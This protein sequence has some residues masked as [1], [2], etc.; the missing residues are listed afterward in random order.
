M[1]YPI[2]GK[3]SK[4]SKIWDIDGNEYIDISMG[5][6][7]NLFG[8]NADFIE[9][10]MQEQM[11]Y[12]IQ[13]GPQSD[14]AAEVALLLSKMTGVERV[15]FCNSGTEAIMTA[16][17]L[18]RTH[19]GRQKIALF[20]GAYH[21]HFDGV[22]GTAKVLNE[23]PEG[24]AVAPGVTHNT[25]KDLIVLDYDNPA[26]FDLLRL[27]QG[28]LAAV[29]V[30]P[31]QS[32]RPHL[33]PQE[34]L[35]QLRE[36]TA[37]AGIA[38]IFDE[39]ITGF[40][41]HPGGAQAHFG[42]K[43]DLVTYGKVIG[44]GLP[45]GVVAGKAAY[46][47]RIDGGSWKYGDVSY[48]K[49]ET[50]FFAGTFCK[51]PLTMAASLA[52]L[53]ELHAKGPALQAELNTKTANL[54]LE[55]N[56]FFT[57][58]GLTIQ[59]VN[60]GSLF[61]F[62][63]KGNIDLL[64]YHL[65]EKGVYVWEGRNCFLST[66]HTQEDIAQ[67]IAKVKES[68]EEL[69]EGGFLQGF[70]SQS[71][72]LA[73]QSKEPLIL[74]STLAQKQLWLLT[75]MDETGSIAYNLSSNLAL[76]GPFDRRFLDETLARLVER[77]EMLRT[78]FSEDGN[79]MIV[80]PSLTVTC[81]FVDFSHLDE[82]AHAEQLKQWN[83]KESRTAF[84]FTQA[85]LFRCH[86]IKL[87]EEKHVI[88]FTV[89][90]I[91]LDGWSIVLVLKELG[92]I[93]AALSKGQTPNLPSPMQFSAFVDLLEKGDPIKKAKAQTYWLGKFADTIPA[94]NLPIDFARP[95]LK[96][97][98]GARLNESL[99]R[100]LM[101]DLKKMGHKNN[102][103][104]FM[105]LLSAWAVLLQKL[106]GQDDFVIGI[107]SAKRFLNNSETVAGYCSH[108]LPIRY[109]FQQDALFSDQLKSTRNLVFDGFENENFSFAELIDQLSKKE[110]MINNPFTR[111]IFN[112]DPMEP[113]PP[114]DQLE[115]RFVS[116][117]LSFIPYDLMLNV[118]E[119]E[120]DFE[121]EWDYNTDLFERETIVRFS[122]YFKTLL[123]QLTADSS[124]KLTEISL[125]SDEEKE[126]QRSK[127]TAS[128][129]TLPTEQAI[130]ALF[131]S[132]VERTPEAIAIVQ[133]GE[134]ITY[135]ALNQRANQWA[136]YLIKKGVQPQ[137][138]VGVLMEKSADMV[139]VMLGIWKAGAVSVAVDPSAPATRLDFIF[140]ETAPAILITQQAL[141]S[142]V[143]KGAWELLVADQLKDDLRTEATTNVSL[144]IAAH[145]LAYIVYTSGSTGQPKGILARHEGVINYLSYLKNTFDLS[146][147]DVVLQLAPAGFDASVRDTFGPLVVG[148]Q[149]VMGNDSRE[150][151]QLLEAIQ[152]NQVTCLL[153]TVPFLLS[154]LANQLL[155]AQVTC[156][157]VRLILVSGEVLTTVV[158]QKVQQSFGQQAL[159]VNQYGPTECT[160]TSTYYPV[161]QQL[162]EKQEA[163][164]IGKPIPGA[165]VYFLNGTEC[166]PDGVVG[167]IC[168]GG[169]GV[170]KGYFNRTDLT[171]EKFIDLSMEGE[172]AK[173][174]YRTGDLGRL[175][176]DGN[177]EFLG[178]VDNQVK[179]RGF[180]VELDEVEAILATY[181]AV[182][183]C[184]VVLD[185]DKSGESSL[186]AYLVLQDNIEATVTQFSEY[187]E[188]RLP[189]YA[190]PSRFIMVDSLP[191][192]PNGKID[193]KALKN[194]GQQLKAGEAY[195][196]PSTEF[197]KSMATIWEELLGN[198][199]IGI[200]DE[201][202]RIG[203]NSLKAIQ[204]IGRVHK[205][206]GKLITVADIFA[207]PSIYQLSNLL[208]GAVS[209][210]FQSITPL[211]LQ[212][213]YAVSHAQR[214][215]WIVDQFEEDQ[216]AYNISCM[217]VYKEAVDVSAFRQ[218]FETL[219]QRHESLR[220][221][222][223]NEGGQPYQKILPF[224][225]TGFAVQYQDLSLLEKN[226]MEAV[227]EAERAEQ[228]F[229]LDKGP[230]LRVKLLKTDEATFVI[231]CSTHHIVSDGWSMNILLNEVLK[232]YYA[233]SNNFSNSLD[234]LKI[235]YKD[236]AAWQ[237]AQLQGKRLD[238]YRAF[239]GQYF[240]SPLP[241]LQLPYDKKR[242]ELQSFR[243]EI[244]SFELG[245][246]L[247]DE[248]RKI[249]SQKDATLFMTLI[250]LVKLLLYRYSGQK[251]L[252]IGI[253]L[254][255]REHR[256]LENQIGFYVNTM[257]LRS[258]MDAEEPFETFLERT[259]ANLL[260]TYPQ[261]MYPFDRLVEDLGLE[262]SPGRSN[263]FD[264]MVQ[265][266]DTH[267]AMV[268]DENAT[269]IR[270]GT[271]D[272]NVSTSK[273]DLTFN[274]S[275]L[276]SSRG[277]EG[278]IEYNTDLFYPSTIDKMKDDFLYLIEQV[279]LHPHLPISD[280][281]LLPLDAQADELD[282]FNK[283]MNEF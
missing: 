192:T 1:L 98:N 14:T 180:R 66:A 262:N 224:E 123:K 198:E 208:S 148:A 210:T 82:A 4:G 241:L 200:H 142:L 233:F 26:S 81:G 120:E 110:N 101:Q 218:A 145:S 212:D 207:H 161:G 131:E 113:F 173:R 158:A 189:S 197:E 23:N 125:L 114:L 116:T 213:K 88:A 190:L 277:I 261:S 282:D 28:E 33:Q 263:L 127:W 56:Q 150:F 273:F 248:I 264:V 85:P 146:S 240:V 199:T 167:E 216:I 103:T 36:F 13:L 254:A 255:G 129:D 157:S 228:P 71:S 204:L 69:E 39:V 117:P 247:A 221:V 38:L 102:S 17:R 178:R 169:L 95:L 121:F 109:Q 45:I 100:E 230:L 87:A 59:I 128:K 249:S 78:C 29:L 7:V 195:V 108:L 231:M 30:E 65:L 164:S 126:Q 104:L 206:F 15:A 183:F 220:T 226:E 6:G 165:E 245:A 176:S 44:G 48:P 182:K 185:Q 107:P 25:V 70:K 16:M 203:G 259:K 54:A 237:N 256:E 86:L 267:L 143:E 134:T 41:I 211:P 260:K 251:D 252:I 93:Y 201:F 68:V 232:L 49:E 24:T 3:A 257:G 135:Q 19:T 283:P 73:S 172:A 196:A 92:L 168:I 217:F 72:A 239:W 112:M 275:I 186:D 83:L 238:E 67:L 52:V 97:Y 202:F 130:H 170:A 75:K 250:A 236:F 171:N 94:L 147:A 79:Q 122:D 53:R 162:D 91:M 139:A 138:L 76:N 5:F 270:E 179:I 96:T 115:T 219:V 47:D 42:I 149:V 12:G 271:I 243:G 18:A 140:G 80:M 274:F 144:A 187:L 22:L 2:V 21:G 253:P 214:R 64:F 74:P 50:T 193:R 119:L 152:A 105:T 234:P 174:L 269:F 246:A 62:A 156:P 235:H 209:V 20:A 222:F 155:Q 258:I 133:A 184:A 84:N 90:H 99:N 266:Q 132:Q 163:V 51:H 175:R 272:T 111:A 229:Q 43:A 8:H 191:L 31:V 137:Q 159:L 10:A 55:L 280:Q 57:Q 268:Q 9:K 118:I 89:H 106:S 177:I 27:Y 223:V 205:K 166:V 188:S 46:M 227:V 225:Q 77:H 181:S 35:T 61:R 58:K 34:F 37:E 244:I 60:F 136:H 265:L 160:M 153:S 278:Y 154:G 11:T 215:L 281:R 32:R 124:Q 40:R 242:P 63:S 151:S 276:D 141:Q 194:Q 279:V